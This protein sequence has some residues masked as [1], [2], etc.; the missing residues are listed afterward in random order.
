MG[1]FREE[2]ILIIDDLHKIGRSWVT[3]YS[4][5][6]RLYINFFYCRRYLVIFF[7]LQ[8]TKSTSLELKSKNYSFRWL[9]Q[10]MVKFYT[11]WEMHSRARSCI[12]HEAFVILYTG[13]SEK[14]WQKCFQ[15]SGTLKHC[16]TVAV[17]FSLKIFHTENIW[18][19]SHCDDFI[20]QEAWWSWKV[21]K[22]KSELSL[23]NPI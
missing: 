6:S 21:S 4:I 17:Y 8:K 14:L 1:K 11:L 9:V 10:R 5:R 15:A 13:K 23:W 2:I 19:S 12:C 16:K 3:N 18:T 22:D 7:Y 20:Q